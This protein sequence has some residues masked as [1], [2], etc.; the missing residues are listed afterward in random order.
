[1]RGIGNPRPSSSKRYGEI[2]RQRLGRDH[3][4]AQDLGQHLFVFGQQNAVQRAIGQGAKSVVRGGEDRARNSN[5]CGGKA[6]MPI[7]NDL[8]ALVADAT[9]AITDEPAGGSPQGVA[10][11]PIVAAALLRRISPQSPPRAG[12]A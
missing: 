9:L 2:R 5:R 1:M 10:T 7:P 4:T 3:M 11:G 6:A 12:R 8:R